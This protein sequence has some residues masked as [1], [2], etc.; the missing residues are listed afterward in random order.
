MLSQQVVFCWQLV[1]RCSASG[2]YMDRSG[3]KRRALATIL[4]K[5][6]DLQQHWQRCTSWC[7]QPRAYVRSS[8]T[9]SRGT[10]CLLDIMLFGVQAPR[11]VV[12]RR[13]VVA[14]SFNCSRAS[15]HAPPTMGIAV[16]LSLITKA[17]NLC[18]SQMRAR[19]KAHDHRRRFR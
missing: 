7:R 4:T 19:S 12:H 18:W 10:M 16:A 11:W 17:I 8:G 14:S 15:N 9:N 3:T 6:R 1:N 2:P 5:L 13:L